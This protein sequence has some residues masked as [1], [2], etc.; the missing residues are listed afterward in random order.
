[1]GGVET[2]TPIEPSQSRMADGGMAEKRDVEK[3]EPP[4]SLT[5]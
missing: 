5:D 4:Y 3:S 2:S 1:M